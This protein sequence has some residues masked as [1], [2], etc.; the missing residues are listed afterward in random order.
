MTQSTSDAGHR[1]LI[2]D[3]V[4]HAY[5]WSPSNRADSCDP[6]TYARQ[7][8]YV[9]E[10]YHKATESLE[11]GFIMSM[12]EFT[13]RWHAE[14]LAHALFVESDVD[15][16]VYHSVE[17]AAHYK[18]GLS[19]WDTG[20]AMRKLAPD[21]VLLFGC[22]D[23]FCPDRGEVFAQMER[24]AAEGAVGFKFYPAS[25]FFDPKTRLVITAAYDDPE[26]GFPIFD[27]AR[28]LGIKHVAFH[29]AQPLA[30]ALRANRVEDVA[31]VAAAFPDMTF[32]VVHAGWAFLEESCL[33][34]RSYK[35]VYANLESVIN[36]VVRA[37]TRFAHVIGSLLMHGGPDRILFATGCSLNHP[38]PVIRAFLKFQIPQ[39]L[40]DG[41]GY[42]QLTDEIRYKILG[43]NAARLLGIDP[44]ERKT[45]IAK[46]RWG[47][48]RAAGKAKPWAARR[49][50]VSSGT[51]R[52]E[53]MGVDA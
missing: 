19:R 8:R 5:D 42:P 12:K 18:H 46:D 44:V 9:Y 30:G 20:L 31:G 49:A 48:L 45:R 47:T 11:P 21:R 25:G 29:K 38:D 36:F 24:M 10:S 15:C 28:Q 6:E 40:S 22:V 17:I 41:Y 27:K 7:G 51:M 50:A 32:E 16:A 39:E 35:N 34:L 3:S 26:R 13:S 53:E 14:E 52:A 2:I 1:G 33:L 4:A 23:T 37:P 43:G